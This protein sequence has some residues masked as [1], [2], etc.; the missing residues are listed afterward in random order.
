MGKIE[1]WGSS[2]KKVEGKNLIWAILL[3]LV[4][5]FSQFRVNN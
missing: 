2:L 5:S 4:K 3:L 1:L